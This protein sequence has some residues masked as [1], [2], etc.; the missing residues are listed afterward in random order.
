MEKPNPKELIDVVLSDENVD[1]YKK[2]DC[3][4]YSKCLT[5]VQDMEQ[6]HCNKCRV[7]VQDPQA[8]KLFK[9]CGLKLFVSDAFT[10]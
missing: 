5:Q 3:V 7:Y 6:F 2:S 10:A 4:Y 1:E 8:P 9:R